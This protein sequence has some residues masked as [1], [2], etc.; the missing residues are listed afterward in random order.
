M[1]KEGEVDDIEVQKKVSQ[2]ISESRKKEKEEFVF[3]KSN[4]SILAALEKYKSKH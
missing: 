2:K 1:R 3:D 4:P